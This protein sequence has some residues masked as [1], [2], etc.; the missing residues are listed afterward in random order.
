MLNH[1]NTPGESMNTSTEL[2]SI[3]RSVTDGVRVGMSYTT[4]TVHAVSVIKRRDTGTYHLKQLCGTS[5]HQ[6]MYLAP[7]E[8]G[9]A[10]TCK[11]CGA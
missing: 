7:V 10:I 6:R 2:D 1:T 11:R 5:R 8:P 3:K 4:G 9:T